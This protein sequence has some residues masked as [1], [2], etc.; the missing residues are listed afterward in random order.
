M[1]CYKWYKKFKAGETKV[2]NSDIVE[3]ASVSE[4][5]AATETNQF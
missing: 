4:T 5:M 2:D 3:E 1:A